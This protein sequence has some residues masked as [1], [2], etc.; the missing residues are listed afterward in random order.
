ML[1]GIP[2]EIKDNETRISLS[3]YGVK[4]L[5]T[6]GTVNKGSFL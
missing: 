2:K 1:I 5:R 3:P 4:D 6:L